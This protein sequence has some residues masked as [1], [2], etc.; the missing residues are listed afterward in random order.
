MA[1]VVCLVGGVLG[2]LLALAAG[3][4]FKLAESS[5]AFVYSMPSIVGAFAVSSLTGVAFGYLPARNAA[6][7]DPVV[8][9]ARE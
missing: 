3:E 1:V 2:I 6:Q 4:A 7:L 5:F 8:A 9:L